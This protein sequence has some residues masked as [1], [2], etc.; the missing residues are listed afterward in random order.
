[1]WPEKRS[2]AGQIYALNVVAGGIHKRRKDGHRMKERELFLPPQYIPRSYCTIAE[3]GC[4]S[5]GT[6]KQLKT[7]NET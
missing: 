1:M 5:I 2:C 3:R 4:D 7:A 6:D